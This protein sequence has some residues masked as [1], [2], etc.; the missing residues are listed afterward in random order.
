MKKVLEIKKF[1]Q[2][3]EKTLPHNK[4]LTIIKI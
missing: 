3:F 2:N 4:T 1:F